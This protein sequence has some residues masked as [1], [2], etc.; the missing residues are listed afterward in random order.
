MKVKK[1]ICPRCKAPKVTKIEQSY[2]V[3]DYCASMVDVDITIGEKEFDANSE[4][5]QMYKIQEQYTLHHAEEAYENKDWDA[6]YNARY[7]YWKT[8]LETFPSYILPTVSPDKLEQWIR[9]SAHSDTY[10]RF[11]EGGDEE[12]RAQQEANDNIQWYQKDGNNYAE[13]NSFMH[14][15]KTYHK[16][17][18]NS[19]TEMRQIKGLELIEEVFP[20][21]IAIKKEMSSFVQMWLPYLEEDK[22]D[23]L[24]KFV[25]LN[26][27]YIDLPPI[28]LEDKPC[29]N[30]G[31]MLQVPEGAIKSSCPK[32]NT[33]HT[34]QKV[35]CVSCGGEN[36]LP[37]HWQDTISCQYCTSEIRVINKIYEM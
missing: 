34:W 3:C 37:E 28:K 33:Q 20:L 23:E 27:E 35:V 36:D 5:A 15:V 25:G 6:Y 18:M 24:L 2:V 7:Q 29:T 30:C 13:W 19:L 14:A 16:V 10:F 11:K 8:Y 12:I 26:T 21:D 9:V 22:Q 1:F 31:H 4:K 17:L 32:C